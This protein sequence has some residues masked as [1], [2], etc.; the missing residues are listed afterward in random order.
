MQLRALKLGL[1]IFPLLGAWLVWQRIDAIAVGMLIHTG[2]GERPQLSPPQD[3]RQ[4]LDVVS[5]DAT[6]RAWVLDPPASVPASKP[7][8]GTIVIL[9][10]I[11]DS[12]LSSLAA[13]RG[14]VQRGYRAVIYDARG[15]GES[16]GRYLTYGVREAEELR[17]LVDRLTEVELLAPPLFVVG[18]SYGAAT[19]LQYGAIDE[20][21]RKLVAVAPFAS[22]REVVPAYLRW[23]LGVSAGFIPS[24]WVDA[25]I[26]E[27][28]RIAG[29]DPDQACP[30]CAAA[31]IRAPVLLVAS[32][33]DER[34]PIAQVS[35]IRAALPPGT[36]FMVVK[37]V[38]HVAVGRA[39]EVAEAIA[40]FL[41]GPRP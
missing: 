23:M 33:D 41:D 39:P 27:A 12:K 19:A 13:A 3:V 15:H 36:G 28:G 18:T 37:G 29:F 38:G 34:I 25:R 31:H 10:G 35:G 14:H 30:R 7:I 26:D 20:R 32:R 6:L 9:H 8:R 21:V 16:T 11:R 1:C 4:T 2:Q 24:R 22:L 17:L 40:A 5:P